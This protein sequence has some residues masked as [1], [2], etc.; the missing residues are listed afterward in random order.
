MSTREFI[1]FKKIFE[2]LTQ[3]SLDKLFEELIDV[4]N[5]SD[6]E[7][8]IKECLKQKSARDTDCVIKKIKNA[9]A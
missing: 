7:S 5:I 2:G 9:R 3:Y 4:D 1:L 8:F 6:L